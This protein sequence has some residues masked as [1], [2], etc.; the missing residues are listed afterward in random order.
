[1]N[2]LKGAG[3]IL[4][5]CAAV[6]VVLIAAD[7][8]IKW[9]VVTN[10]GGP[11]FDGLSFSGAWLSTPVTFIPHILGLNFVTNSGAAWSI[12][13]NYT[14]ILSIVSALA[15]LVILW[16][17]LSRRIRA[18][19]EMITLTV[20]LAGA[21]GNLID[22]LRLGYVVDMFEV[23]FMHFPVFN[24]ADVCVTCGGICFVVYFLFFHEKWKKKNC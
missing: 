9:L 18:P 12:L 8:L 16:L 4:S 6:A 19:F 22:R 13:S 2:R 5:I 17:L 11:D 3:A 7:Q 14:W 10:I 21:A 1:M 24:F 20:V 15:I 23:L